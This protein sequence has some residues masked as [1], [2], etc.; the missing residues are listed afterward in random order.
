MNLFRE[1][2][3]GGGWERILPLSPNH[4]PTSAMTGKLL[5]NG[6]IDCG[7]FYSI[8]ISMGFY[9]RS[10]SW[11][12]NPTHPGT[13]PGSSASPPLEYLVNSPGGGTI[14][15]FHR[16]I[17]GSERCWLRE[18]CG[19]GMGLPAA[20]RGR[21]HKADGNDLWGCDLLPPLPAAI[22]HCR[23]GNGTDAYEGGK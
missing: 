13:S 1:I 6:I 15:K 18:E 4:P 16:A 2:W 17:D 19:P 5:L 21:Q 20:W 22:C 11:S 23:K 3:C 9:H 8:L 14:P 7:Y 10:I 12:G